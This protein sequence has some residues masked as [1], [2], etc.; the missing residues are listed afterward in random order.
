MNFRHE[1]MQGYL[2]KI[3]EVNYATLTDV[4]YRDK[5]AFTNILKTFFADNQ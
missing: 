3:L 2:Q 4:I 1:I 5:V